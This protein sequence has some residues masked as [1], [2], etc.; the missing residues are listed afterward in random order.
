MMR[1]NSSARKLV[2]VLALISVIGLGF[3]C[4]SDDPISIGAPYA[5]DPAVPM[6]SG[7][8]ALA[9]PADSLSIAAVAS[10]PSQAEL[11]VPAHTTNCERAK[12][13]PDAASPA[14]IARPRR[15]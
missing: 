1:D 2:L 13:A 10:V 5:D 12:S 14:G 9:V 7:G 15:C 11:D 4:L 8:M 3:G 6:P